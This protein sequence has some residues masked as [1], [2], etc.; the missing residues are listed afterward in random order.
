[1][2]TG[3]KKTSLA[4]SLMCMTAI[5][6][7]LAVVSRS[8]E[9]QPALTAPRPNIIVILADDLGYADISADPG[10]RF[11]TPNIDRIGKEGVRFTDGYATAPVCAPSRAGLL[12]GRYQERFGEEYNVG[13][14]GRA[15]RDGLGLPLD[16]ITIAQLLKGAG[17]HTGMIGK[18]H[19]GLQPQFYPTNRGFDE[20]VGFLPGE[21]RY[22]DPTQPGV[23]L[24]F[25]GF[26]DEILHELVE[27]QTPRIDARSLEAMLGTQ[28]IIDLD[29]DTRIEGMGRKLGGTFQRH[30]L[31]E[32]VEGPDQR[33]VHNENQYLTDYFADR[34][35][36]FIGQ[37][38]KA[39]KPYSL[40]LAFNAPH[41]PL[42]V[43]DKYYRRFPQIKDHQP[44]V[45]AAMISAL[46][47]GVGEILD[48]VGR[49]GQANDTLIIFASDNGCAAYSPGLC[50]DQPLRGG[51]LSF[52]EGGIRVP[53]MMSWPG[54]IKPGTV[55]HNPVSL[56]DVLPTSVAVAGGKLPSDRAYDG[57]DLMPYL[58]GRKAGMPHETLT[59]QAEPLAAIRHG[60]WKLWETEGQDTGVYG[61]YKLLFNLKD[62]LNESK[63]LSKQDPDQ[64]NQ[65]EDLLHQWEAPM[66]PPK[67][68]TK[69]P[70]TYEIDGVK[71]T[72]PV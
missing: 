17:Y 42:M 71:F 56:L 49:S 24:A 22:I 55:Y 39:G 2:I 14:A 27:G 40:Y 35:A 57:V 51:K 45:Y 31:S 8:A 53:Y 58:A 11:T 3:I 54:H 16:Q 60:E 19:E 7:S 23:H 46:D 33:V 29:S 72:L 37:N 61:N 41:A 10:G 30:N 65:L 15:L 26:S 44:R 13:G 66:I 50:S 6:L 67:W 70:A 36:Q 5:G 1:L 47:D 32:I 18:W 63:N 69:R 64:L 62:D 25:R 28:R 43:T 20:F 21:A 68:P 34:A 52:F 59:W 12:T 48:A 9:A 38:V 4:Q